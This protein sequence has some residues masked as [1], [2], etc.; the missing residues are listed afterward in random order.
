MEATSL[1]SYSP[2]VDIFLNNNVPA[3]VSLNTMIRVYSSFC[4]RSILNSSYMN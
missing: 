1:C 4:W 3:R 2:P